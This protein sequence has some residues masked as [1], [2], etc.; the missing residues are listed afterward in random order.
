MSHR[1]L[2]I[3]L[4]GFMGS[5]K[6][7]I[8]NLLAK[9]LNFPFI[10]LDSE[11]EKKVKMPISKIFSTKGESYFREVESVVLQEV[12]SSK[13]PSIIAT[14]GG[15]PCYLGGMDFIQK[16]GFSFYLKVGKK[17]LLNRIFNDQSR[18]LIFNKTKKEL[19]QFIDGSLKERGQFYR[20]ANH[21]ILAFDKPQN[22]VERILKHLDKSKL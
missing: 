10:D 8:G 6:S 20:K 19:E 7:T 9:S 12:L 4:I 14:G 16:Y 22:L 21:T 2:H 1:R 11:I 15:T 5:G 17:R 3:V 18:P 13:I